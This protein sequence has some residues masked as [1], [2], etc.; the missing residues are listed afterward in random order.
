MKETKIDGRR[1]KG[2]QLGVGFYEATDNTFWITVPGLGLYE[3]SFK[4]NKLPFFKKHLTI[5][6]GLQSNNILSLTSDGQNRLWV[7]TNT[8]LDILQENK[9]D[10]WVV[11]NYAKTEDLTINVSD[12]EKLAVD[13]YGNV[14]L[15]SPN[16][17][18]KFNT[19]KIRLNKVPPR[20]I[21]EK[22]SLAFKETDWGKLTDSLYSYFQLPFNPVLS[23]NQN[24]LGIFFNAIDLSTSN[25]NPVYSYKLLPLDTSWSIPSKIKSVSFA[26][27][28]AG[29][30]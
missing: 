22:V 5:K 14:W 21:I 15:S 3:Y 28:P 18:I 25:S 23:Y 9:P 10:N 27:L 26:Q 7:A 2:V 11:F 29:K 13:A 1:L 8:G 16:K 6:D 17:I 30:I 24:S 19:D 12:F 20:I 4:K